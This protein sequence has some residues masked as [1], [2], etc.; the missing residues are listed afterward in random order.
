MLLQFP[1]RLDL[2][3]ECLGHAALCPSLWPSLLSAI[4]DVLPGV[5]ARLECVDRDVARRSFHAHR[6]LS[7][8][9]RRE[10]LFG[11]GDWL[12]ER[13]VG[14]TPGTLFRIGEWDCLAPH[15]WD[16]PGDVAGT[17]LVLH[18]CAQQVWLLTITVS[19]QERSRFLPAVVTL[20]QKMSDELVNAFVVSHTLGSP[21]QPHQSVIETAWDE[22]N[23]PV[24]LL[25]HDLSIVAMNMEADDLS[26]TARYFA[27]SAGRTHLSAA[28]IDDETRLEAAVARI[29]HAGLTSTKVTLRGKGRS[30]SLSVR[31]R[32]AGSPDWR[33][34]FAP[35]VEVA[36]AVLALFDAVA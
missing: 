34:Q 2:V 8:A 31:L 19:R 24:M 5:E 9:N 4:E 30:D 36:P 6:A 26:R 18:D 13:H 17:G 3:R 32:A 14:L 35:E 29:V 10:P 15:D 28:L 1:G 21:D 12:I 23:T 7:V 33:R 16:A 25:G 20:L 11:V 27:P 22:V